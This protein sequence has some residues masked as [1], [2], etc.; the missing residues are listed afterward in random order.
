M[1]MIGVRTG[2]LALTTSSPLCRLPKELA[3]FA[4]MRQEVVGPI[5]R[6]IKD[7]SS[8]WR[9]AGCQPIGSLPT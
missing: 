5:M 8:L 4:R 2:Y 7:P 9:T 6:L 3:T 1:L